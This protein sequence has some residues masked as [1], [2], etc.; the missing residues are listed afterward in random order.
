MT[1]II[2]YSFWAVLLKAV[3]VFFILDLE[4]REERAMEACEQVSSYETCFLA[5][6]R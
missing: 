5:I 6:K 4:A 1:R 3:V 2:P